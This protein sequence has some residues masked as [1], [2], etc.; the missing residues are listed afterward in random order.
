MTLIKY[1]TS[2]LGCNSSTMSAKRVEIPWNEM[3]KDLENVKLL[4]FQ[5][6]TCG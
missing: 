5:N 6:S 1:W 4:K 3:H 2:Y